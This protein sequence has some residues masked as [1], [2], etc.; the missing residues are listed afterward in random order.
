GVQRGLAGA[1]LGSRSIEARGV[2]DDRTRVFAVTVDV[3]AWGEHAHQ[4]ARRRQELRE[5]L[6]A[7]DGDVVVLSV[8]RLAA[9]KG[10]DVL[11]QAVAAARG[12][13]LRVLGA[14]SGCEPDR[15]EALAPE[16]RRPRTL[17]GGVAVE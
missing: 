7:A 12:E 11:I 3:E 14:G 1:A 15:L 8:A 17:R 13:R 6:G 2:A 9:E 5:S 10:L 4:L 16:A